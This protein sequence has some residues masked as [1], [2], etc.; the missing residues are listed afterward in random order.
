MS[1]EDEVSEMSEISDRES[2][3]E[4]EED[5]AN[6]DVDVIWLNPDEYNEDDL[7]SLLNSSSR[8]KKTI[9]DLFPLLAD[10]VYRCKEY[11]GGVYI[12]QYGEVCPDNK[13]SGIYRQKTK[14]MLKIEKENEKVGAS[15]E[16]SDSDNDEHEDE[17][18]TM[19]EK[20]EKRL[21]KRTK[22]AADDADY[23]PQSEES[24]DCEDLDD[25]DKEIDESMAQEEDDDEWQP[26]QPR[27]RRK[28]DTKVDTKVKSTQK[29]DEDEEDEDEEEEDNEDGSDE[30]DGKD[31]DDDAPKPKPMSTIPVP[32]TTE[33]KRDLYIQELQRS[34]EHLERLNEIEARKKHDRVRVKK[35]IQFLE[36][37]TEEWKAIRTH[38]QQALRKA[39]NDS[40]LK[41][42]TIRMTYNSDLNAVE[43]KCKFVFIK[44]DIKT[45][46]IIADLQCQIST[47]VCPCTQVFQDTNTLYDHLNEH[48]T[49]GDI[50]HQEDPKQIKKKNEEE[51]DEDDDED[52]EE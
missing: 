49:R 24:E 33:Q 6:S 10:R 21:R 28:V 8:R 47:I 42:N 15:D 38:K 23:S 32:T 52:S 12:N 27:K 37:F 29:E 43:P 34:A 35:L 17:V 40:K 26:S 39:T 19:W 18:D 45:G 48:F 25:W 50:F 1:S 20:K 7:P 22:S 44:P 14:D 51:D 30:S 13:R 36:D 11:P 46:P 2:H 5:L 4:E 41:N 3:M 16:S 9:H 31:G